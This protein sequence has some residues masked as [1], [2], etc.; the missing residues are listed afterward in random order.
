MANQDVDMSDVAVR[1]EESAVSAPCSSPG[2]AE[3][4]DRKVSPGGDSTETYIVHGFQRRLR[5]Y[6]TI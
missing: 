5:R 1:P 2:S 4:A 6:E 3:R